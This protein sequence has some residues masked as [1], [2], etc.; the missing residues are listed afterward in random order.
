MTMQISRQFV[1]ELKESNCN[2]EEIILKQ[3]HV[4]SWFEHLWRRLFSWLPNVDTVTEKCARIAIDIFI[5][6][7]LGD[8]QEKLEKLAFEGSNF[9]EAE[10]K[11][12]GSEGATYFIKK[13]L[14]EKI[15]NHEGL[16]NAVKHELCFQIDRN[17][18]KVYDT[19]NKVFKGPLEDS[20]KKAKEEL[21]KTHLEEIQRIN[22]AHEQEKKLIEESLKAAT[23]KIAMY[24]HALNRIERGMEKTN[25]ELEDSVEFEK[26]LTHKLNEAEQ[27][28]IEL[29][30]KFD[31]FL[32][33]FSKGAA[34]A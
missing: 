10:V 31:L 1:K 17:Q 5:N 29:R 24:E 22:A 27:R 6:Q 33:N 16:R 18:D 4:V 25:K 11:I 30:S 3:D 15:L 2:Y 9:E 12:L 21:E 20:F 23:S 34:K 8:H 7:C 19:W 14:H 28:N 26:E 13:D 32:L